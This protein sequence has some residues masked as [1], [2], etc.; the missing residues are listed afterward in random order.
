MRTQIQAL[1]TAAALLGIGAVP[2]RAQDT[3]VDSRWLAY[4]GCW[5]PIE[6][7]KSSLCIVPAA[8]TSSVDFVTVFKGQ[9][10]VR[11]PGSAPMP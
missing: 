6:G 2:A 9:V 1:F 7:S 5:E 4:L 11:E 10:T 8:G 3:T